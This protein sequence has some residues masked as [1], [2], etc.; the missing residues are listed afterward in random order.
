MIQ[1][2]NCYVNE[3][4]LPEEFR[5]GGALTRSVKV[6]NLSKVISKYP[7]KVLGK[8]AELLETMASSFC[9]MMYLD[10]FASR[11]CTLDEC[12]CS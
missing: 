6:I 5:E 3:A 2:H 8:D 7:R 9:G 12:D 1:D 10:V 11:S 4:E